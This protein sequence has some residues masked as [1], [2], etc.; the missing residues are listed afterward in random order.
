MKRK[1]LN[2]VIWLLLTEPEVVQVTHG[3]LHSCVPA[4]SVE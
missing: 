3:W 2:H 4:R 1:Q